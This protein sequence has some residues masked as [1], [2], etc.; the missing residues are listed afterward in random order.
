MCIARILQ[1]LLV[2]G[3]CFLKYFF[4]KDR[5]DNLDSIENGICRMT[6]GGWFEFLCMYLI[7]CMY[8]FHICIKWFNSLKDKHL[9]KF[10]MFDIKDFCPSVTQD[11]LNTPFNLKTKTKIGKL[12]LNLLDKHFPPH[13]KLHKFFNWTIVKISYNRMPS[14]NSYT[15]IYNK[16]MGQYLSMPVF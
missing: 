10:V 3:Y 11:L 15:Y 8:V 2:R 4:V 9:S 6:L 12:F 13:S 7:L 1:C 5:V 14:M 16:T